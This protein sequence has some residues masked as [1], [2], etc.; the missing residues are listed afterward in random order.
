MSNHEWGKLADWIHEHLPE[1]H[2]GVFR[3]GDYIIVFSHDRLD[4]EAG[5]RLHLR[6][7]S[8]LADQDLIVERFE[9]STVGTTW[10]MAVRPKPTL[11]M[12]EDALWNAWAEAKGGDVNDPSF[13]MLAMAQ[14][15]IAHRVLGGATP[16]P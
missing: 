9:E 5:N 16:P 14:R 6:I 3:L 11:E 8:W 4:S 10:F 2:R 1:V 7:E 13:K 15:A 12:I